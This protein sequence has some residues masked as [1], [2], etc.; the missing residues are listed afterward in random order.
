[1]AIEM[2]ADSSR[3]ETQRRSRKRR[4]SYG[5]YLVVVP[6]MLTIGVFQYY[7]AV[8]GIFRSFFAWNPAGDSPFVG[9]QNYA[10][11]MS[12]S[13]WWLSFRNLGIIFV[14]GVASWS[15]PLLAAE[16]VVSLRSARARFVFRTLLILPMAFPGVVTAL[17][18][19]FIYHPND[20]VLNRILRDAGLGKLASNWTGD[21]ALALGALLFIGF[22]FIAGLPF[23][24]FHSSLSNIPP[25]IFEAAQLDGVG[26][27]RRFWT[28]DLPLMAS[29]VRLLLFLAVV[30]TLQY[31]FVAYIVTKGGPDN[32]T[33]V[34]VL[35]MLN[36]AFQG[37]DW[38]YAATLSTTLFVITL[39]FSLIV[40][41]ARKKTSRAASEDGLM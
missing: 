1:M 13:A 30:A 2:P 32:A 38:G 40:M 23:L 31:G 15:I 17:I 26:R 19:S 33:A 8:N 9:V 4:R 12:D 25:E 39:A 35:Q 5:P 22:P 27:I 16:L 14:F 21:P 34:P 20:G 6:V 29:Q 10:R 18:W 36:E 41:F 24:I 37:G 7:P 11:M 3:N 28:I